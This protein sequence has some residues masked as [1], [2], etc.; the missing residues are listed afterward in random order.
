MNSLTKRYNIENFI[1]SLVLLGVFFLPFNSFRGLGLLGEFDRDSCVLFFL[2]AF[3]FILLSGRLKVP[4]NNSLFQLLII[5]LL[6]ALLTVVLNSFDM[7]SYYFKK[8]S[9]VVRFLRQYMALIISSIILFLTFYN[10]LNHKSLL[11]I[12]F[13]IRKVIL[14]SLIIVVIYGSIEYLIV[15]FKV[16]SLRETLY[17]FNYL[18]FTDVLIDQRTYRIS[19][20]T[21]EPPALA[22]YLIT[23]SGLMFSYIITDKGIKRFVPALL[24][25]LFS[26]LS[27]SRAGFFIII[28]QIFIF[29]LYILKDR[30]F[31]RLFVNIFLTTAFSFAFVVVFFGSTATEYV[32][33]ELTSFELEDNVH[34]N[35]NK[36]RFGIQYALFEV[37]KEN[38]I[39]G[40][41]FGL[42]AFESK[43]KYPDWAT[44]NNWE[45]SWRYLNE[46]EPSF[47]P[48]YN[49][50]LRLLS[51]TGIIGLGIFVLFLV[52]ILLC[53]YNMTF[54]RKGD[55]RVLGFII[56]IS[57]AG[58]IFNWLKMDTF[59]I[60]GFWL[61]LALLI[62]YQKQ[63][64]INIE[65][66]S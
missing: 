31:N 36:T 24:V 13:R 64:Q 33:D 46:D 47:P 35:S 34:A 42:Q 55:F 63:K 25:V 50:Y 21:F 2:V 58:Y 44:E 37:F 11:K 19:S 8:T 26:F 41:G 30:K 39:R 6:W 7:F 20:V 65:K 57:M 22:T 66:T 29:I 15:E 10:A 56:T 38:P 61:C 54:V 28:V 4:Y 14:Y 5:F 45:F 17:L 23:A 1:L 49:M 16:D 59:R 18:P 3:L 53:C 52:S 32:Y 12:V 48:G 27:G 9:G 40:V 62:A 51:E 60:Y 43:E